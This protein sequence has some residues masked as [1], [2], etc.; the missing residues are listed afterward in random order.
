MTLPDHLN[1][2]RQ[3]VR[4]RG[5]VKSREQLIHW[6]FRLRTYPGTHHL[7]CRR[8]HMF[9][10]MAT[11]AV[12]LK[13]FTVLQVFTVMT[14]FTFYL[15]HRWYWQNQ[16]QK[17]YVDFMQRNYPPDFKYQDFAPLF[18]AEFFD[19]KEWTDIFASSGAKYIVLTTKHHEGTPHFCAS[20]CLYMP[21]TVFFF[22]FLKK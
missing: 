15:L 8:S 3:S 1:F 13:S 22:F 16:T 7:S 4:A 19:A 18:T 17:P 9:Y 20:L 11:V 10:I 6:K 2:C 12:Q 21:A 14:H 5:S